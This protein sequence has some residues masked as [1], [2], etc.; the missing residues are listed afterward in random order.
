MT[1]SPIEINQ[2]MSTALGVD[3]L[4]A[5]YHDL[6]NNQEQLHIKWLWLAK[7]SYFQSQGNLHIALIKETNW[8][9][10]FIF[11]PELMQMD[12]NNTLSLGAKPFTYI[13]LDGWIDPVEQALKNM[14]LITPDTHVGIGTHSYHFSI[15]T[16]TC[17]G[18]TV[19]YS[20]SGGDNKAQRELWSAL[21][22]TVYHCV[23]LYNIP[24]LTEYVARKRGQSSSSQM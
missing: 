8:I 5:G 3:F 24:E 13:N 6:N 12:D 15:Y 9:R 4:Q 22:K 7:I 2:I 11:V 20:A 19:T 10:A 14:D 21:R 17:T 1:Y 16:E 18:T 23:D